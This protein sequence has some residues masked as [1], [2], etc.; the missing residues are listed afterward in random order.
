[1]I[2]A[3][4]RLDALGFDQ[5]LLTK[6]LALISTL[7]AEAHIYQSLEATREQLETVV[8]VMERA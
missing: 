7:E 3:R 2:E 1:M 4:G 8:Q 5:G 6:T